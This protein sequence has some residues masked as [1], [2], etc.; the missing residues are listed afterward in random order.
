MRMIVVVPAALLLVGCGS[1]TNFQTARSLPEGQWSWDVVAGFTAAGGTLDARVRTGLGGGL[2]VGA[3][4]GFSG[5]VIVDA[6][7]QFLDEQA[8]GAPFSAALGAGA[9]AGPW[10]WSAF[11]Q[12]TASTRVSDDVEIYFAYRFTF[13]DVD[14]GKADIDST[15]DDDSDLFDDDDDLDSGD[16][17][18]SIWKKLID[19]EGRVDLQLSHYFFGVQIEL[20]NGWFI[21][22]EFSIV[23][24]SDEWQIGD[25]GVGF[26][27]RW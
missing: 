20:G 17:S 19:K 15:D 6:K 9:G 23:S 5:A 4:A 7:V 24:G 26:G 13:M 2:E 27:R 25:L 3:S 21:T 14:A 8:D 18:D 16:F 22:P 11:G 1:F 12:A 10:T